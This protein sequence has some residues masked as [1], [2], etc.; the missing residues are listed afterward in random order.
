[1]IL[2]FAA[3]RAIDGDTHRSARSLPRNLAFRKSLMLKNSSH[4]KIKPSPRKEIW[5]TA[6]GSKCKLPVLL[7]VIDEA[8]EPRVQAAKRL[9]K[10]KKAKTPIEIQTQPKKTIRLQAMRN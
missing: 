6:A 3:D 7:T 1:M 4:S 2:C 10:Y 5:A 8:N 9:M